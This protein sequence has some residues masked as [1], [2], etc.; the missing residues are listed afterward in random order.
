MN[1]GERDRSNATRRATARARSDRATLAWMSEP[2]AKPVRDP[3]AEALDRAPVGEPFAPELRAELDAMLE[4]L[5]AGR[6]DLVAHEDLPAWLEEESA[7][8][9]RARERGDG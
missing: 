3:V 4:D 6:L 5:R 9:E 8:E 1:G 2:A 7:R